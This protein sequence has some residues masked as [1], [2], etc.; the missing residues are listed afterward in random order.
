MRSR[1]RR[2]RP[3][4]EL[5]RVLLHIERQSAAGLGGEDFT[6]LQWDL[7]AYG[8][9]QRFCRRRYRHDLQAFAPWRF[10]QAV[11]TAGI[12]TVLQM[13]RSVIS[14]DARLAERFFWRRGT[15]APRCRSL[16]LVIMQGRPGIG[17]PMHHRFRGFSLGQRR[18]LRAWQ[19][20]Q[21]GPTCTDS[22][23]RP[24]QW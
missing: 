4:P 22:H 18:R 23:R 3:Y 21:G 15:Q 20:W 17:Q 1:I 11:P 8:L 10:T 2:I 14:S 12:P 9:R 24:P 6:H 19:P 16:N 5:S 7:M 13:T